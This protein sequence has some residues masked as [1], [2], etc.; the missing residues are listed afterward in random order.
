LVGQDAN[1]NDRGSRRS[2][3]QTARLV[4]GLLLLVVVAA[5]VVDNRRSTRLG[6]VFGDV[7]VPLVVALLG[8]A[9]LGALV[10]W[11]LLHRVR[12]DS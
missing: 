10:G 6:Y 5:I 11:L 12:Q 2:P 3:L 9:V 8:A 7:R 1:E 4:L